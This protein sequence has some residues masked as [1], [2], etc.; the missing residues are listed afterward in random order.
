MQAICAKF[1]LYT[2]ELFKLNKHKGFV[3]IG[4]GAFWIDIPSVLPTPR[5]PTHIVR[6]LGGAS[7]MT[8]TN[9][10]GVVHHANDSEEEKD[11]EGRKEEDQEVQ[12]EEE[13]GPLALTSST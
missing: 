2:D 6:V 10:R 13:I 5:Q 7:R 4:A 12:E 3:T 1:A 11:E 9:V 8:R